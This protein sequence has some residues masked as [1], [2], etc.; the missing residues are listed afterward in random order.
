MD[1]L[2]RNTGNEASDMAITQMSHPTNCQQ[3]FL[4]L[5][6]L[7]LFGQTQPTPDR[8]AGFAPLL[9]Q[10]KHSLIRLRGAVFFLLSFFLPV[11]RHLANRI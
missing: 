9:R 2:T 10:G 3:A 5:S 1:G 6:T 4:A 7:A 11:R 8:L